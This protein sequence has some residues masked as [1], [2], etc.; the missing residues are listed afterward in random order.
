M[1]LKFKI[2]YHWLP[3]PYC[4]KN[5]KKKTKKKN[6]PLISPKYSHGFS[7]TRLLQFYS[8]PPRVRGSPLPRSTF[9]LLLIPVF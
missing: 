3:A 8:L 1:K 9:H 2:G 7:V 5:K 4:K 6:K